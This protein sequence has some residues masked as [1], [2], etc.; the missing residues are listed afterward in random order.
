MSNQ[1]RLLTARAMI[2][3]VLAVAILG[4]FASA[5][6]WATRY[7]VSF[8]LI[9]ALNIGL[10]YSWNLIS[11]MTGYLSFG[12]IL[13]FGVGCY[14]YAYLV[15]LGAGTLLSLAAGG[16]AAGMVAA[17]MGPVLLRLRGVYFAIGT[18][19]AMQV[20]RV[21]GYSWGSFT[22]GGAGRFVERG[23][24]NGV[25]MSILA[26]AVLALGLNFAAVKSRIG[27]QLF[28]IR[29]DEEAAETLGVRTMHLKVGVFVVSAVIPGILG[30]LYAMYIGYLDPNSV[31]SLPFTIN[32]VVIAMLGG[33]GTLWGPLLSGLI[34]VS[35]VEA[36]WARYPGYHL[37]FSGVALVLVVVVLPQ[38]LM[39]FVERSRLVMSRT[40]YWQR[41]SSRAVRGGGS[42]AMR[43]GLQGD[44]PW[45][46]AGKAG[47]K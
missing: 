12:H 39:A 3:G 37:I 2:S 18:L 40:S 41:R 13:F 30:G 25:Y 44:G 6:L 23:G 33:A 11:G 35:A 34:F 27:L 28:A 36:I 15:Q 19:A 8:L 38:G 21:M 16:L 46:S 14:L 29:E 32:M 43:V 17:V 47:T 7:R 10:A 31:F 1:P 20:G 24:L 42:K 26:V 9:L 22:G 5:P 4:G 45:D